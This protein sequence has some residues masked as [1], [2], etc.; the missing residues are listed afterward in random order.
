MVSFLGLLVLIFLTLLFSKH[1]F[2]VGHMPPTPPTPLPYTNT[3]ING[4]RMVF[5]VVLAGFGVGD[6][7]PVH[8]RAAYLQ[9][10]VWH[11]G[12]EVGRKQSRGTTMTH[13]NR[14]ISSSVSLLASTLSSPRCRLPPLT[15]DVPKQVLFAFADA[16]S[17]FVF[18][19]KFTDHPF[20]FKVRRTPV[21]WEGLEGSGSS[22]GS[23]WFNPRHAFEQIRLGVTT[24]AFF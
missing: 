22:S 9:N 8:H 15:E 5:A 16:G 1:P 17:R 12:P 10:L 23:R 21:T 6:F 13:V 20:V 11:L 4:I 3:L 18:G 24:V 14:L 7:D 19:E 2:R